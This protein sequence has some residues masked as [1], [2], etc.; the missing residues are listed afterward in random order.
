MTIVAP[1][2]GGHFL[3]PFL[4]KFQKVVEGCRQEGSIHW[5]KYLPMVFTDHQKLQTSTHFDPPTQSGNVRNN[6]ALCST[7]ETKQFVAMTKG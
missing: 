2:H 5:E 7:S 1:S 4:Q 6:F 3:N